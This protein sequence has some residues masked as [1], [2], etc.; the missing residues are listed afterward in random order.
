MKGYIE[1]YNEWLTLSEKEQE[2]A[3]DNKTVPFLP[4]EVRERHITE[5]KKDQYFND[6]CPVYSTF[7]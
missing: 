2:E 1:N 4:D 5:V 7:F 3:R 6:E